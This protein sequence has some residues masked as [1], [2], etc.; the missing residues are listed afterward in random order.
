MYN[1]FVKDEN[2]NNEEI[3]I[4]GDD[5][6]H[7]KNVLR[8]KEK[9]KIHICNIDTGIAYLCEIKNIVQEMI[10]CKIID[11]IDSN[12]SHIKITI[13]QGIPKAGKMENIIQKS[14]ELG[15]HS[16]VPVK[17][18]YCIGKINNEDKKIKR[19][20]AIAESAAKQSKRTII[21][22]VEKQVD[23]KELCNLIKQYDCAI[24]AYENEQDN[25]IKAELKKLKDI[26][27]VAVIIGPEGGISEKEIN[28][29][30]DCGAI[31]VSLGKRI[32]RTETASVTILSMLMYELEL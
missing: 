7:I 14:V 5:Y 12:E 28:M 20:Q 2:K 32:L 17:M 26:K 15:A 30:S 23:V 6:N 31:S 8:L 10:V 13:F 29:L 4:K 24:V 19:W 9:E 21:P 22:K 25:T 1:F 3:V 18:E 16:I 27:N 11:E